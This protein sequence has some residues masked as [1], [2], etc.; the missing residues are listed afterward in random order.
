MGALEGVGVDSNTVL[1]KF[2]WAGDA[3][4]DGQVTGADYDLI[5]YT[6]LTNGGEGSAFA[7]NPWYSGDFNYDGV[8]NG[9]DYDL[10][11]Y[12][13]LTFGGPSTALPEPGTL[14]LLALGGLAV[15]ARRNR[16]N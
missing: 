15:L 6:W 3:D 2:T 13:W 4:L 11:D 12:V 14:V 1:V 5:D 9:A 8:V 7:S 16:R 10:I